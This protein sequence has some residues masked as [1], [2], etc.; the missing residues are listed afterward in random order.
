MLYFLYRQMNNF[1]LVNLKEKLLGVKLD[2]KENDLIVLKY[3]S[4]R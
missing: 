1:S 2:L 3:R 4:R